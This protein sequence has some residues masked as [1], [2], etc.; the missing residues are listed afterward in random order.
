MKKRFIFDENYIKKHAKKDK[1]KI[2][3]AGVVVL[4]IILIIIILALASRKPKKPVINNVVPIFELKDELVIEAGSS[5]PDVADYFKKL[6]NIDVDSI[7][8]EYPEDFEISYDTSFCTDEENEKINTSDNIED[9][10]CVVKTLK[11]PATYGVS[12]TIQD[13]EYTVRLVVEDSSAPILT[14]K[15]VEIYSGNTYN[16]EDFIE[17]CVD[18]AGTCDVFFYDKDVDEAGNVIDY[19]KYTTPGT[20]KVRIYAKD[21][22][23]NTSDAF[24]TE[25]KIMQSESTM[26]TVTFNS[27]GGSSVASIVVPEGNTVVEPNVPTRNGYTFSGWYNGNTIFDFTAGINGDITLTAKWT[28]NSGGSTNPKPPVG[29]GTINVTSISLNFKKI[30]LY[31]GDSKVVTA[32]AYP[33]NATNKN[34]TWS[35]KDASIATV[36]NGKIVGVKAGTTTITASAGGIS[37]SVEVVVK[38]K[39]STSTCPYGDANYNKQYIL[40]VNLIQNNCAVDPNGAYNIVNN[41]TA[42]D[43]ANLSSQLSSMGI[44]AGSI[45]YRDSYIKVK[46]TAGTGIVG[47]QITI[48][49]TVTDATSM[50]AEYII[51]P[52]GSRQFI[53]NNIQKGGVSFR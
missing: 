22:Y 3:I 5:I 52:D 42:K 19:S 39:T 12:L 6:E 49:V 15:N 29:P 28:K 51:K 38:N 10:E 36:T 41:V 48:N 21:S 4:V 37:S 25:L 46:N 44:K 35:S 17:F 18:A 20:Y 11:T 16:L 40:S 7:K 33:S 9:Y 24:E 14:L 31:V 32:T 34:I 27:N 30:N 50:T 26:Y 8:V 43:Y 1:M 53:S 45:K 47:Y 2:L 23:G 13:K